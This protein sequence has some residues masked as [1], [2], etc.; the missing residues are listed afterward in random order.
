MIDP[1]T[2]DGDYAEAYHHMNK[3]WNQ[4]EV[5]MRFTNEDLRP[6][7]GWEKAKKEAFENIEFE[8]WLEKQK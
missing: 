8:E 6:S 4:V 2:M 5:D 3:K 1:E 7:P